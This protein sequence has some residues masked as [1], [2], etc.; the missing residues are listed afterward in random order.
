[1]IDRIIEQY[2]DET[3]L[4]ADGFDD[5]IIGVDEQSM[6]L[7][8]SVDKCI[9]I[10]MKNDGMTEEDAIEYLQ[11]NTIGSY[12]GEKTPV[13]CNDLMVVV[14]EHKERNYICGDFLLGV[15]LGLIVS[16]IILVIT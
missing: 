9:Q 1:M 2:E 4:K 3:F 14:D 7:I 11:F 5:A 12:V 6:R 8:Y 15:V 10:L 16:L 13:W